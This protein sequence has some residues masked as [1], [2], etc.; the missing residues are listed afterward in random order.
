VN[1]TK[2]PLVPTILPSASTSSTPIPVSTSNT[3]NYFSTNGAQIVNQLGQQARITGINWMGFESIN[4]I[5]AGLNLRGYKSL[6]NQIKL[7][8]FNTIRIAFSNEMLL[9]SSATKG[10][11]FGLNPDLRGLTPLQCLDQIISY[12]A[13]IDL[14]VILAR[15][16]AQADKFI[17]EPYWYV[18]YDGYYTKQRFIDDWTFLATRYVNSAVIGA[19]LWHEPKDT[20]SWGT[21]N[22]DKDWDSA[23]TAAGN[24]ILAANPQ[25]LIIVEGTGSDTWW[26]GNLKG[27]ATKPITLSIAK[28]LVYS[29]HEYPQEYYNQPW[30]SAANYP[31]NLRTRWNSFWGY[32]MQSINPTPVLVGGFGSN[33]VL[34]GS[35]D[36]MNALLRYMNGEFF[37]DGVNNIPSGGLGVSWCYSSINP[38]SAIEGIL[39]IDWKTVDNNKFSYIQP[40]LAPPLDSFTVSIVSQTGAPTITPPNPAE[41]RVKCVTESFDDIEEVWQM[42]LFESKGCW[43]GLTT[44]KSGGNG[45]LKMKIFN[46]TTFPYPCTIA[47]IDSKVAYRNAYVESRFKIGGIGPDFAGLVYAFYSD[48]MN[49]NVTLHANEI[50]VEIVGYGNEGRRWTPGTVQ[51]G[52]WE[53]FYYAYQHFAQVGPYDL[54]NSYVTYAYRWNNDTIDFFINGSPVYSSTL[55]DVSVG[56][57]QAQKI[58]FSLWDGSPYPDFSA[59]IDWKGK[60]KS[61]YRMDIDYV[62]ICV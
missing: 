38:E 17:T 34:Q 11:N 40:Q 2:S 20:V 48:S 45:F 59:K 14:R 47:R 42:K 12:C 51:L 54:S 31:A 24:A 16:S 55:F 50:D 23:A 7:L 53:P 10:I 19:D 57:T 6:L 15:Y 4:H 18:Q 37:S 43:D 8:N 35:R 27:V 3:L 58:I 5:A 21:G 60:R 30:F 29:I 46:E 33:E 41:N 1:P 25:W 56:Y 61:D 32:I 26:G 39:G 22:A 62:K 36:W 44:Y 52:Y 49:K 28:K 9:S 13:T